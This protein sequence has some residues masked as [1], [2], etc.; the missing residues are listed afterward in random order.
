M[1]HM[2]KPDEVV[3]MAMKWLKPGGIFYVSLPNIE[4]WEAKALGTYWFGLE[5]PRHLFLFSP[6]SLR[7][8][9][10]TAGYREVHLAT[11]PP[12]TSNIVSVIFS[13]MPCVP[14]ALHARRFPRPNGR[15][16][17]WRAVRR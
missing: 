13:T 12:P 16:F 5:L 3:R 1:E 9:F 10:T 11:P 6:K 7:R 4:S 2:Y 15:P 8:L 17:L 14:A